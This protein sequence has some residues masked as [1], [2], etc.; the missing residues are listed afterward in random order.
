MWYYIKTEK[1]GEI[2]NLKMWWNFKPK[3][4]GEIAKYL[5][6]YNLGI[7]FSNMMCKH[8]YIKKIGDL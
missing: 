7:R 8:K 4:C 3:K 5:A 1:G 6:S 2:S